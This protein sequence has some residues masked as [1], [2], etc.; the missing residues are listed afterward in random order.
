MPRILSFDPTSAFHNKPAFYRMQ[1]CLDLS[2]LRLAS[3]RDVEVG[4]E[5]PYL[6]SIFQ[7]F[8]DLFYAVLV[9]MHLH[10]RP[11]KVGFRAMVFIV[12]PFALY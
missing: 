9:S 10:I 3:Y 6:R 12:S 7:N 4:C 1:I 2:G 8:L 5:A 11:L